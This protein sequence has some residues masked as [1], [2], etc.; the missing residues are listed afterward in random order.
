VSA[1]SSAEIIRSL[2]ANQPRPASKPQPLHVRIESKGPEGYLTR[3]YAGDVPIAGVTR[4]EF[5]LDPCT[6]NTLVLH[7]V[8]ESL[9]IDVEA[10][11][12]LKEVVIEA[13]EPL[14]PIA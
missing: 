11:V 6:L 12:K 13:S 2:A 8:P 4:V 1:E 14:G 3:V 5:I 9:G 7:V 10:I